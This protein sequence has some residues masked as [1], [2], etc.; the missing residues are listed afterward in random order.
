MVRDAALAASGLLSR[1]IGG[2][3]VFPPQ[4]DG[5][6][7]IPYSSEKWTPSDGEDRYRRGLYVFIRRSAAYPSFMTFDATSRE[8]CT[9][10]RVRTNTP[11]QAL[12]T[13]NDEAFFEAAAGARGARVP[14][15]SR[16]QTTQPCHLRLPPRRRP[17]RRSRTKSTRIVA[18]YDRQL[19]RFRKDPE[20]AA[21]A[22]KGYAVAGIDRRRTGGMDA[23][24]QRAPEPRRSPDEGMTW[25]RTLFAPSRGGISSSSP[26]SAS[27]ASRCRALLDERLFAQQAAQPEDGALAPRAPHFAPKAKNIIY[28]FMAGAP[29]QLDL[30]DHKPALQKYDGQEIP[31]EFIPKGERF[32]FIKGTPRLLG[33][34]FTF[35]KYGQSGAELSELLPHL[36]SHRRRH[37]H[38]PLGP[39]D[40]VQ[41]RARPDL[42]EHGQPGVRPPERRL[43]AHLRPRQR[44]PRS[45]RLRRPALGRERARRRQVVLGKRISADGL[46]GR[47]VPL[48]GRSGAVRVEPGRRRHRR[49]ARIDRSRDRAEPRCAAAKPAIRRST[50]ASRRTRWRTGCRAACR[51]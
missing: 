23:R 43:V 25:T 9:V 50:R 1:K 2:P 29:T 33:S 31:A 19:E 13:L 39:H 38:R 26:A 7:D 36:A 48:E 3:S 51:S 14:R 4:P 27:A 15:S 44:E 5:I 46:P 41:P 40:A 10:R 49:A 28:L 32:A 12:T 24:R 30:F 45:A 20:A 37:R 17:A 35:K 6:W 42:H 8:H 21:R 18:S 22:I 16:R 11:L 47:R 34:P